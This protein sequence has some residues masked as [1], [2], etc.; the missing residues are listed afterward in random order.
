MTRRSML[1]QEFLDIAGTAKNPHAWPD[2]AGQTYW[3][4]RYTSDNQNIPELILVF[5]ADSGRLNV[6]KRYSRRAMK[7]NRCHNF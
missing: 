2:E 1:F 4:G 3:F 7:L 5:H 6:N